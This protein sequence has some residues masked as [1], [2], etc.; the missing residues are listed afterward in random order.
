MQNL[1]Q[2]ELHLMIRPAFTVV[3]MRKRTQSASPEI[4]QLWQ[5]FMR[6]SG[7][8]EHKVHPDVVYGVMDNFNQETGR[9]DYIAACE[10]ERAA[11]VP[12]G[13]VCR[14][15]PEQLYA[16]FTCTLPTIGFVYEQIDREW[17]PA[18]GYQRT[19]GPEFELYDE[20]FDLGNTHS[21]T[22]LYIPVAKR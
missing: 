4:P 15:V 12:S 1:L 22:Y 3:G 13:M 14:V 8:I 16:I 5:Q 19:Y 11:D 2:Q 17:L 18:A 7:D 21:A 20:H 9:F 10:V 6:R